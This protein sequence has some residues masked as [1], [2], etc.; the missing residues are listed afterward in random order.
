MCNFV[1]TMFL[2]GLDTFYQIADLVTVCV[3]IPIPFWNFP[4]PR[5]KQ[6]DECGNWM[7]L[8]ARI[9]PVRR[10]LSL[11]PGNTYVMYGIC[12]LCVRYLIYIYSRHCIR[13]RVVC[14]VSRSY[15]WSHYG[16]ITC[17]GSDPKHGQVKKNKL[18]SL[19]K[20]QHDFKYKQYRY[21]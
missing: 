18:T 14:S 16:S 17:R 6:R 12:G 1:Y 15:F 5:W 9:L 20:P 10:R 8:P 13:S 4:S 2:S 7:I 11:Q 19:K 3:I 21:M